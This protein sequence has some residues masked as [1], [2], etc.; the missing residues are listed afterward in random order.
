MKD[1]YRIQILSRSFEPKHS[2]NFII[3]KIVTPNN[4]EYI[5]H[6]YLVINNRLYIIYNNE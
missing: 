5:I 2:E 3:F 6:Y 4:N 1:A